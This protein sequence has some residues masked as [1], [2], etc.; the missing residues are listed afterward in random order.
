MDLLDFF[1]MTKKFERVMV[2]GSQTQG[3]VQIT[4]E[5]FYD[6]FNIKKHKEGQNCARQY[7]IQQKSEVTQVSII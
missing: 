7:Q 5:L 4:D 2:P 6:P 3:H 1:D